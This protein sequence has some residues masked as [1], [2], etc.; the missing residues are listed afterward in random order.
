MLVSNLIATKEM[1]DTHE[2]INFQ[3]FF[4]KRETE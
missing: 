1:D 3:N 2:N 4:L